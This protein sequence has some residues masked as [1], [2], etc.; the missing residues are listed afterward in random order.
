MTSPATAL[1]VTE[2]GEAKAVAGEAALAVADESKGGDVVWVPPEKRYGKD[3]EATPLLQH[4]RR[5]DPS[6]YTPEMAMAALPTMPMYEPWNVG[7]LCKLIA[8]YGFAAMTI[9]MVCSF[10]LL[11]VHRWWLKWELTM[12]WGAI[13]CVLQWIVVAVSILYYLGF[14]GQMMHP[15]VWQQQYPPVIAIMKAMD[16]LGERMPRLVFRQC[17]RGMN[18]N[19]VQTNVNMSSEAL[20]R[21][22]PDKYWIVDVCTDN[23]I[24]L[25]C[26][27]ENIK[28]LVVPNEYRCPRGALY[29]ARALHYAAQHCEYTTEHDWIIHLDEETY[30]DDRTV[31]SIF[32]YVCVEAHAMASGER[33]FGRIG[34]GI[35]QYG[36]S[37]IRDEKES[38]T[39]DNMT[40]DS[41]VH[42]LCTL[43]D[44]GRVA[45]DIGL[46][47]LQ[48]M[49][50]ECWIGIHGSFV[51]CAVKV[52]REVGF[53][54]AWASSITE[55][56][57]FSLCAR[58]KGVR[59]G[60][61][62]AIM[63]E[64]SP[65]TP[66]D[67]IKQRR[68]W[69]GGLILC[70]N[71]KEFISYKSRL[72]LVL[73]CILWG[74]APVAYIIL[75]LRLFVQVA[76]PGILDT[77]GSALIAGVCGI[78]MW[79]YVVGFWWTFT[80]EEFAPGITGYVFWVCMLALTVAGN[81]FYISL[82]CA[83]VMY[84]LWD[85]PT[86]FHVVVKEKDGKS[87]DVEE[88]EGSFAA[89]KAALEAGP[90]GDDDEEEVGVAEKRVLDAGDLEVMAAL[91]LAEKYSL[92]EPLPAE[93]EP[94]EETASLT[95][96]QESVSKAPRAWP[97]GGK[98]PGAAD[99]MLT[100]GTVGPKRGGLKKLMSCF[101]PKTLEG[102]EALFRAQQHAVNLDDEELLPFDA[103]STAPSSNLENL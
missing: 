8:Y 101:N 9:Y 84:A 12:A 25:K 43:A 72:P 45:C 15:P 33:E 41:F 81:W 94:L 76:E 26:S 96:S 34:Q 40:W 18:P 56:T 31:I 70:S 67:F 36:S 91:K 82:E 95:G 89:Q 38:G 6:G 47:R 60:W 100:A 51:V 4:G 11:I 54:H 20:K 59:F 86:N 50:N 65:F 61:V 74:L 32:N 27:Q 19:L 80:A 2:S 22:L 21:V 77:L 7:L 63:F 39:Y 66:M 64:Q 98:T 49:F 3:T 83:G 93:D 85:P 97:F 75:L 58:D 53:D 44:V 17:T 16:V 29:K 73:F 30:F 5:V 99:V 46:F 62:D 24:N 69:V 10:W 57:F 102:Q 68:R 71:D 52:E 87:G 103:A 1:V 42:W 14:L 48:Y 28:E 23:A 37:K 88:G 35:I 55:D 92:L 79:F 78:G 90:D 13:L